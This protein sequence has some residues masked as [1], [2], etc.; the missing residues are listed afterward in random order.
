MDNVWLVLVTDDM[1]SR[2]VAAVCAT[3][4]AVERVVGELHA[5]AGH[6]PDIECYDDG[7]SLCRGFR[8]CGVAVNPA[9]VTR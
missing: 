9:E 1:G 4:T 5:D 8:T 7:S 3:E 6:E 2:S